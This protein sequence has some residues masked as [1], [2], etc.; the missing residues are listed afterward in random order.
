MHPLTV[1]PPANLY[2]ALYVRYL[3]GIISKNT[4]FIRIEALF[5]N[6]GTPIF[7]EGNKFNIFSS[8]TFIHSS[9]FLH[10]VNIL[11]E[12]FWETRNVSE[13]LMPSSRAESLSLSAAPIIYWSFDFF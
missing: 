7:L 11:Y 10:D 13:G 8:L 1:P 3:R 6:K 12:L 4:I 5:S 2:V 9:I